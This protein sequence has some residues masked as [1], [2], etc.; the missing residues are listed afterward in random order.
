[1][2]LMQSKAAAVSILLAMGFA[3]PAG[4]A[5]PTSVADAAARA[6]DDPSNDQA[7]SGDDFAAHLQLT[8]VTQRHPRLDSPYAGTNSL[9]AAGR[10]E[11]TTDVTA[12]LGARLWR[13]AEL[14]ANPEVDQGFGFD[15]TVG[16]AGFP[17]GEAYKIGANAPY[18]RVPRL[19]VRQTFSLGG[20]EQAVE[21]LA[22]QLGASRTADNL[23]VTVGKFSVVDVFDTNRFA[24]DPRSDFLNW[25]LID[26]G[27]FDYAADAWGFTYGASVE[28]NQGPWTTRLGLFQLSPVPNGK[29][30]AVDFTQYS[31]MVEIERRH[32]WLGAAGTVKLLAFVNRG[33]MGAYA[34][35]VALAERSNDAPDI[36]QVRRTGSRPGVSINIE[37]TLREGVGFFAR[38]GVND[39]GK[40]AYEFTEINRTLSGG[41]SLDGKLWKR[42]DD[43]FGVAAVVN[44]LSTSAR[45]YFAAGGLGILI[46]DGR[47]NYDTERIFETY[48]AARLASFATF[49]LDY[50]HITNPA[51]NRDR[52]PVSV[53]SAR[54]HL[55]R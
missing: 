21:P 9:G 50:Q 32:E 52:G 16:V 11:Q 48:Y 18:L 28:L 46:G 3:C 1:M 10:T 8:N 44:A 34:D 7:S 2:I 25:S 40:E 35:A 31:G 20:E 5:D 23:T 14:W 17:S 43:R 33:R 55:E 29:I 4:A 53:Y 42:A 37:Q 12:Y 45:R 26:A 41:L 49:S 22:N 15:K 30:V 13:G 47:L 36:T 39:G 51:Y 6:S 19:F 38:A 27:T 24:H 54:L